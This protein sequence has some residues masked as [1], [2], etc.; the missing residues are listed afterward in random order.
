MWLLLFVGL[1]LI[2]KFMTPQTGK[3]IITIH[4]LPNISK[5]KG[6]QTMKFGQS[7]EYNIK[8]IFL[9]KSFTKCGREARYRLF[10][11]KSKLSIS[12]NHQSEEA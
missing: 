2:S 8:N 3:Q 4:I 10:Y 6:K 1:R 11:K 9:E 7:I 5:S 12:V